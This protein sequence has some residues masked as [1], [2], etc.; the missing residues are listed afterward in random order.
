MLLFNFLRY[1]SSIIQLIFRVL[2]F[3]LFAGI[4]VPRHHGFGFLLSFSCFIISLSII[5]AANVVVISLDLLFIV[6][7]EF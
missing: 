5:A 3:L 7:E 4:S 1:G 2:A 6:F